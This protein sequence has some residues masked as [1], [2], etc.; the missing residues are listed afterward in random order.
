VAPRN[1]TGSHVINF[2]TDGDNPF[3]PTAGSLLLLWIHGAV[4]HTI[5]GQGW[6]KQFGPVSSGELALFTKTAAGTVGTPSSDT[7]VTV[8]HNGSN[9]PVAFCLEELPNGST[10]T[11]VDST[12]GSNDTAVALTGLPGTEQLIIAG[13]GRVTVGGETLGSIAPTAPLVED[14]DL[15][16]ASGATDGTYLAVW[17]RINYTGTSITPTVTPTYTGGWGNAVREKGSIAINAVAPT[18]T[19]P[20]TKDLAIESRVLNTVTKDVTI[21]SRVLAA[22]TKDLDLA[23]RVLNA[24]TKDLTIES[25][26]FN[27]V[28]KDLAV[29]SRVLNVVTKDLAVSSRV[30]NTIAQ[31]LVLQSRVLAS[32]TKDLDVRSRVLAAITADLALQSRVLNAVTADLTLNSRVLNSVTKDLDIWSAVLAANGFVK[33]LVIESRLLNAV[34]KDLDL[35]SRVLNPV[36]KDFELQSRVLNAISKDLVVQSRL[37]NGIV[38]DLTAQSRVLNFVEKDLAIWSGVL[39]GTMFFKDLEIRSRVINSFQKDLVI[40]SVVLGSDTAGWYFWDGAILHPLT[41]E[42]VWDGTQIIPVGSVEIV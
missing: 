17:H 20:F 28:T 31:D 41:L 4:T 24:V 13:L 14:A 30:L 6:T 2:T 32:V 3:T 11:G 34:T 40:R 10:I 19:T 27:T 38:V 1:G 5:T 23:S 33:D 15:F 18:T 26:L 39:N 29:Q 16:S 25:R 7:T 12:T 21:Q 35:R 36:T 37:F 9:Y 8:T 22:V 42:G